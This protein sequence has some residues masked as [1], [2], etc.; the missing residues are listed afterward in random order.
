MCSADAMPEDVAK[1]HNEGFTGYWTKPIDIIEPRL[2][3]FA[4]W[5]QNSCHLPHELSTRAGH[6]HGQIPRPPS[7]L[8][9]LGTPD[10]PT[11]SA[12]APLLGQ[13]LSDTRGRDSVAGMETHPAWHHLRVRPANQQ[14]STPASGCLKA[15][16]LR[17]D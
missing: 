9:N 15:L 13:F 2:T 12:P 5:Q 10:E 14:P 16:P 1:A 8:V 11:A 7:L 17:G 6:R 3:F 4:V